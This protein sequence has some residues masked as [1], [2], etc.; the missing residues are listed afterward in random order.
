VSSST[1]LRCRSWFDSKPPVKYD[2]ASLFGGEDCDNCLQL[3]RRYDLTPYGLLPV[4]VMTGKRYFKVTKELL[5]M[6][7]PQRDAF[8]MHVSKRK[9]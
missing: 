6:V 4:P 1:C 8:L 7:T 3:A 5:K 9:V 2:L